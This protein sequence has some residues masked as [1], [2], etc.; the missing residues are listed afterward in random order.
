MQPQLRP[1][2]QVE[3]LEGKRK[4]R[5]VRIVA[6]K[7][8]DTGKI[9]R[10]FVFDEKEVPA[11]Y[12]VYFPQGHSIRVSEEEL[13]RLGFKED[14]DLV[15]MS[16]GDVLPAQ[17]QVSLKELTKRRTKPSRDGHEAPLVTT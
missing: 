17:K 12:M 1:Q 7:D 8:E 5:I 2:Y 13:V 3:P 15:D 16:T 14:P 9:A 11:G 4:K 10:E 6:K